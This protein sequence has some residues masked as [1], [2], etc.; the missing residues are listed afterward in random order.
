[1]CALSSGACSL[2]LEDMVHVEF[3]VPRSLEGGIVRPI[4]K[5]KLLNETE[6]RVAALKLIFAEYDVRHADPEK[7]REVERQ[8]VM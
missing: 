7:E 6:I 5:A 1:M 4:E 2:H 8:E 3:W